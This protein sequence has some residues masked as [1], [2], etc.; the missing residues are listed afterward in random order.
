MAQDQAGSIGQVRETV[1]EMDT[2]TQQN[3]AMVEE[4]TAATQDLSAQTDAL[5]DLL[6]QFRIEAERQPLASRA[7]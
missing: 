2:M 1:R 5:R 3:A 7:A 6:Q 4:A